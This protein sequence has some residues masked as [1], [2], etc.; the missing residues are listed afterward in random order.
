MTQDQRIEL[1]EAI[2]QLLD[3]RDSFD[4]E[5]DFEFVPSDS[6][7]RLRKVYDKVIPEVSNL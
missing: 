1:L 4:D 6:L 3:Q 7:D 5:S 2:E